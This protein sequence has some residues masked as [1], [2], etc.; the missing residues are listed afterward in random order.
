MK[1]EWHNYWKWT[2]IKFWRNLH[3]PG[4]CIPCDWQGFRA[5]TLWYY[6]D[7]GEHVY[8]VGKAISLFPKASDEGKTENLTALSCS[9]RG[10]N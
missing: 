9:T 5:V 4:S 10:R 3:S 8:S 7:I 1:S 2:F 6:H